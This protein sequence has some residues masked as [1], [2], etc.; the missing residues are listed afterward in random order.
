MGRFQKKVENFVCE[1]C[2]VEVIGN[3]YTN[4]CPVCLWSK[5][6]DITPGDREEPCRGLMKPINVTKKRDEVVIEHKCIKCG[7]ERNNKSAV[8]DNFDAILELMKP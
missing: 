2:G 5:H 6:V 1:N 8:N 7:F 4:H 3:G